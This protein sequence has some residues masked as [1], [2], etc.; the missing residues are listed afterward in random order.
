MLFLL[1]V[2]TRA[3]SMGFPRVFW[4]KLECIYFDVG[5]LCSSVQKKGLTPSS[6]CEC[7]ATGQTISYSAH[8]I[9]QCPTHQALQGM[10]LSGLMVL[11]DETICCM[12]D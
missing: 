4:V 7:G 10:S 2:S 9:L 1:R 8:H 3:M 12:A 6:N 5:C 11:N